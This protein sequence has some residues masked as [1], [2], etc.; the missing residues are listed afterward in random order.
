MEKI[1]AYRSN[2]VYLID[3]GNG[4]GRVLDLYQKTYFPPFNL[5]SIIAR[6]YWEEYKGDQSILPKLKEQILFELEDEDNALR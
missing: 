3:I 6:G 2:S 4:K 5:I 1:I